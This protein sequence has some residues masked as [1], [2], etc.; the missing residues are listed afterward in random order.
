MRKLKFRHRH[1]V[2]NADNNVGMHG[3]MNELYTKEL[4]IFVRKVWLPSILKINPLKFIVM[5]VGGVINGTH[6]HMARI[7]ISQDLSS[8]SFRSFS[9]KFQ[10]WHY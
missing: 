2:L 3:E 10:E 7:L 8:N 9:M 1:G 6:P 4:V 5:S